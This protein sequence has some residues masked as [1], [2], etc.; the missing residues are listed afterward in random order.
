MQNR[1][2]RLITTLLDPGHSTGSGV[3]HTLPIA[4][5]DRNYF[6]RDQDHAEGGGCRLAQQDAGVG[7]P[8]VFGHAA[9]ASCGAQVDAR[10]RART[11]RAPDALSFK[12]S[13]TLMRRKLPV[14]DAIP[15]RAVPEVVEEIS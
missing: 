3:G 4:L 2:T 8:G 5:D 13:L 6:R 15:P 9:G 11:E 1:S 12:H 7:A 10:S 14:S